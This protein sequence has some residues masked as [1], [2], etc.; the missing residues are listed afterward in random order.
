[1]LDRLDDDLWVVQRPLTAM[2]SIEIASRMSGVRRRTA[3]CSCT[4]RSIVARD[5]RAGLQRAFVW[6]RRVEE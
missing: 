4:R 5:A 6:R 2:G 1:M 3:A